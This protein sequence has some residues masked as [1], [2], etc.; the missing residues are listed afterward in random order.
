MAEQEVIV[1]KAKDFWTRNSRLILICGT[2]LLV[3]VGGFFVYTKFFKEPKEEKALSDLYKAEE[4]YRLDSTR[5]ALN[6]DGQYPGLLR[7]IDRYS[8]TPA[9]N[10]A[11]YMAGVCYIKMDDN[12]NAIKHLEKF[13]GRGAKQIQQRA[14]K[15]LGDAYAAQGNFK[16]AIAN[17]K[18]AAHE[19]EEDRTNAAEALDL[20]AFAAYKG[21]KD[22][23]Q[24]IELYKELK[25]KFPGTTQGGG[26]DKRLA[27]LGEYNVD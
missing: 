25:Q 21:L 7:I 20:A 22:N 2:V 6:G 10:L 4:Y 27:E 18:K 23:K 19:F 9:A 17:Y 5:L 8:G 13:S 16:E 14:Y 1:A 3:I 26:A 12:A 24:A 15:L 11:H